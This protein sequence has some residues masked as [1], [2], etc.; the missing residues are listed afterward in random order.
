[1]C[2]LILQTI[3]GDFTRQQEAFVTEK[4]EKHKKSEA[5]VPPWVGYN[6][7]N[8]MKDQILALSSVP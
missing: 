7:E 2:H 5:A 1:M 8:A 6:E 3:I 4:Q